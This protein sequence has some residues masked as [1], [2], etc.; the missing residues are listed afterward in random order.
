MMKDRILTILSNKFNLFKEEIPKIFL[1]QLNIFLIISVLLIIKPMFTS[2]LLSNHGMSILP[3]AYGIIAL[4]ALVV[5]WLIRNLREWLKLPQIILGNYLIHIIGMI[6]LFYMMS[7]VVL[8]SYIALSLYVYVSLF[9]LITVTFFY[10]FVQSLI[11]IREAKRTFAYIGSGAIAGGVFGGY[12]ASAFVNI[13]GNSGL[14]LT[15]A[16]FLIM[17]A[18]I[19]LYVLKH[20][21]TQYSDSTHSENDEE[22]SYVYLL[23]NRHVFHMVMIIGLGVICAKLIDYQFNL[24]SYNNVET[25]DALTS[26]LGFWFSS[27]N[28]IGLLIQILLVNRLLDRYGLTASLAVMPFLLLLGSIGIFLMPILAMGILIK[29]IDGSLKQSIYKTS[30]ELNIMPLPIKFRN[31]SK[32]LLDVVVDSL[33]T[34][35]TG[36]MIY[37]IVNWM[38][39]SMTVISMVT[40]VVIILWLYFIRRSQ[41]SYMNELTKILDIKTIGSGN[42]IDEVS[43]D[44]YL[45]IEL[46]GLPKRSAERKKK[47]ESLCHHNDE[48]IKIAALKRIYD[49]YDDGNLRMRHLLVEKSL[50]VRFQYFLVI[51]EAAKDVDSIWDRYHELSPDNKIIFTAA[52]SKSIGK[53]VNAQKHF[54]IRAMIDRSLMLMR[55]GDLTAIDELWRYI[56]MS[57]LFAHYTTQYDVIDAAL[58][59]DNPRRKELAV[60]SIGRSQVRAYFHELEILGHTDISAQVYRKAI[61]RYPKNLMLSLKRAENDYDYNRL[62]TL[63]PAVRHTSSRKLVNLL[64]KLLDHDHSSIRRIALETL[65]SIKRNKP[66]IKINHRPL[67]KRLVKELKLM[68]IF[69]GAK[70]HIHLNNRWSQSEIDAALQQLDR[71]LDVVEEQILINIAMIHNIEAENIMDAMDS[72]LRDNAIDYLDST[73]E[74]KLRSMTI[75]VLELKSS[76]GYS[77]SDFEIYDVKIPNKRVV[78]NTLKRLKNKDMKKLATLI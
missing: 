19:Y 76:E 70:H 54:R 3:M 60:E 78:R 55:D 28:I 38:N 24:I 37:I 36:F 14:I 4:M 25:Q 46:R 51:I 75:P 32:T 56:Y 7:W 49:E 77:A 66:Y 13:I 65:I 43:D 35:L 67:K 64:L 41:H 47:L 42:Q 48:G 12:F 11:T 2:A 40:I 30:T 52:L 8:G 17:A 39:L 68:K 73:M 34:G 71:R 23:K 5:H 15:C 20:Y 58:I 57:I 53:S 72:D 61:A 29:M 26:F 16:V 31:A 45:N 22:F 59:G 6:T 63:I 27:I 62:Q 74:Y 33:A 10:Q 1:L 69:L 21:H 50:T 9:A 44:I 18:C